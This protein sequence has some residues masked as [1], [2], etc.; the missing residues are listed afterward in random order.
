MLSLNRSIGLN[1]MRSSNVIRP[2]FVRSFIKTIPQPPGHIVGDVNDAYVPPPPSKS[3][4]SLHWTAER[5]VAVGMVPLAVA[6]LISGTSTLIDSTFSALLL[7]HVYAGFQSCIIDYIP[8]RVYGIY[9]KLVMYLLALGTGVAGYGVYQV[10]TKE[11]GFAPI[12]TK[13]FKA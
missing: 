6:P 13:I 5:V 8:K 10:E 4:G 12:I 7:Y 1:A 11:G 3:H 9:H 2:V